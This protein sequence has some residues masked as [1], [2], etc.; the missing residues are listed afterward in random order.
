MMTEGGEMITIEDREADLMI[1]VEVLEVVVGEMKKRMTANMNGV[2]E[3]EILMMIQ[4]NRQ[5]KK[6]NQTLDYLES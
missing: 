4:M 6:I 5:R 3:I 2:N 1:V